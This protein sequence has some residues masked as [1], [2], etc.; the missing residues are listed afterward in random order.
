MTQLWTYYLTP[1][2]DAQL[3][4][5]DDLYDLCRDLVRGQPLFRTKELAKEAAEA[6]VEIPGIDEELTW[7]WEDGCDGVSADLG[8]G[9]VVF[10]VPLLF[11]EAIR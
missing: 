6:D 1:C 5:E 3:Y 9:L 8:E 11:N 10:V 2:L 7:N 4:D